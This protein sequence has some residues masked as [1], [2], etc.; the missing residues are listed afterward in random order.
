MP[1]KSPINSDRT[2]TRFMER[3]LLQHNADCDHGTPLIN[4]TT[5]AALV[6]IQREWKTCVLQR[7]K[8]TADRSPAVHAKEAA[9]KV[10]AMWVSHFYQVLQLWIKRTPGMKGVLKYYSIDIRKGPQVTVVTD[11]DLLLWGGRLL[12]GEQKRIAGG[13]IPLSNPSAEEVKP[14]YEAFRSRMQLL[15]KEKSEWDETEKAV[16]ALRP[17][18]DGLIVDAIAEVEFFLRKYPIAAQRRKLR[19]YGVTY[20]LRPGE[21][22]EGE[23]TAADE[24]L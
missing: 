17:V 21:I 6:S 15:Q 3:C 9:K 16:V 11:N 2:R 24:P 20:R 8:V 7:G 10:C 19:L 1:T 14:Y 13:G 23:E 18:V 22:A 4:E 12:E 5:A